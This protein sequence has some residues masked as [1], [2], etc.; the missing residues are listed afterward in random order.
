[1]GKSEFISSA[2]RYEFAAQEDRS[3][4]RIRLAIP[5]AFRASGGRSYQ[6][7]VQDLSL[8]GFC[9]SS[10]NRLRPGT[11]CWLTL[12]GLESLQS[13][14]VWCDNT[15]VVCA[16]SKL[17]SPIVYDNLRARWLAEANRRQQD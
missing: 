13:E 2:D 8:G 9:C 7:V 16:L 12:P 1:M 3:A 11:I 6:T 14:V 17:L 15:L 10:V 4:P 5:A